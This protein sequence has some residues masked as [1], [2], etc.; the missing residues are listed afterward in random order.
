MRDLQKYTGTT[1][2]HSTYLWLAGNEGMEKMETTTFLI[3]D[4]IETAVMIH[5]FIW[6]ALK[7]DGPNFGNYPKPYNLSS[8]FHFLFHYP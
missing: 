4:S 1:A 8:S 3:G 2:L 5:S 7:Y 6:V